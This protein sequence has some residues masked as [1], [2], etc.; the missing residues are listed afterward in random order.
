MTA[1]MLRP[2]ERITDETSKGYY[3]AITYTT[4]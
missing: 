2:F 4:G 1:F 3:P